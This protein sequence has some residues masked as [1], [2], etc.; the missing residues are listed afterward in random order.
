MKRQEKR[1][2]LTAFETENLLKRHGFLKEKI[3]KNKPFMAYKDFRFSDLEDKFG[4][5][6]T[7]AR[8]FEGDI[9]EIQPSRWLLETLEK[10]KRRML[11]TEKIVSEALV[12]PILQEIGENNANRIELFSGENLEAD[13]EKGLNGEC[14]FILAKAPL[15]KQIKAPIITI[16]EA[17]RGDIENHRS[18]SQAS[19]QLIGARIFNQKHVKPTPVMYGICTTGFDWIFI[20]LEENTIFIDA[21]RYTLANLP[22]LL[23]ILQHV[24]DFYD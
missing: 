6:Q 20:K 5:T 24:V 11:I 19:S 12:F 18:Q 23:G 3:K 10:G 1:F 17:I 7:V 16:A 13:K 4:I 21:E 8:L 2:R 14:D 9:P 22:Q 15:S